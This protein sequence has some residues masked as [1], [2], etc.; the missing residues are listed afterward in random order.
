MLNGIQKAVTC[1]TVVSMFLLSIIPAEGYAAEA[2][3]G[4]DEAQPSL[5]SARASLRALN[6]ACAEQELT[7]LLSKDSTY[8]SLEDRAGAHILLGTVYYLMAHQLE[9][10]RERILNEFAE[11]F[12]AYRKWSGALE[13]ELPELREILDEA[14]SRVEREFQ[15][16]LDRE[17]IDTDSLVVPLRKPGKKKTWLFLAG[18]AVLA[19]VAIIVFG[20][21]KTDD[22]SGDAGGIPS[23]PPPPN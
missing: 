9:Q 8:L 17:Q 12:R 13:L 19:G 7:H 22:E 11:A 3:C 18:S 10:Q 1:L 16:E 4:Y 14:R 2:K 6:Y 23:Y 15:A 5:A 20:S 21:S